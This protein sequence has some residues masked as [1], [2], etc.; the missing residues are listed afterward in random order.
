MR[1]ARPDSLARAYARL[2]RKLARIV[3]RAPHEGPLAFGAALIAKRPEVRTSVLPLLERYAELRYG[4]P[5]PE[6]SARDIKEFSRDVARLSLSLVRG[7]P[8]DRGRS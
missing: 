2:C 3:P 1:P 6:T 8:H 4:P 5:S 7:T